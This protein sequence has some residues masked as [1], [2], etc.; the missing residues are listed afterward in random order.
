MSLMDTDFVPCESASDEVDFN[1]FAGQ[2][3]HELLTPVGQVAA[4]AKLLQAASTFADDPRALTLLDMLIDASRESHEIVHALLDLACSRRAGLPCEDVDLTALC[5]SLSEELR[6]GHR[7]SALKWDIQPGMRVWAEPRLVRMLMRNLLSNAAKYTSDVIA[8]HVSV[9]ASLRPDGHL[10]VQVADNGA[11]FDVH[12]AQR[13]FHP[14]ERAHTQQQ[15]PG[16][17]LGL[18]IARRIVERHGG[19]VQARGAPGQGAL[20]QFT[21]PH[22]SSAAPVQ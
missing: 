20:L 8:A 12:H 6:P 11:G 16:S 22:P 1:T 15:F 10:L 14:F 9:T 7:C 19:R 21:L 3:A 2:L 5:V 4:I 17:G 13:L 18:A